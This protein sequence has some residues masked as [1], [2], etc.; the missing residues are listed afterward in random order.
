MK[1]ANYN[2]KIILLNILL[3][4]IIV[5]GKAN[6]PVFTSLV[7]AL[8]KPEAVY[9]LDLSNQKFPEF[10][11]SILKMTHLHELNL[12]NT[13]L[14]YLPEDI[15]Q[16]KHLRVLNVSH[17]PIRQLPPN[18]IKITHLRVLDLRHTELTQLPH[19][20]RLSHLHELDISHTL[21]RSVPRYFSKFPHLRH[22]EIAGL[23]L[24]SFNFLEYK[25][26]NYVDISENDFEEFP[27][28]LKHLR[29][30]HSLIMSDLKNLKKLPSWIFSFHYLYN[31]DISDNHAEL[32][33]D[34]H[35]DQISH[36][37]RLKTLN[38]S[39]LEL[40]RLPVD[41]EELKH[42]EALD[43]SG[44][45]LLDW[46]EIFKHLEKLPLQKLNLAKNGI[47]TIDGTHFVA[48]KELNL[49]GNQFKA[50]PT[51]SPSIK[52]LNLENNQLK[53][54]SSTIKELSSLE[55]LYL[56]KNQFTDI[57]LLF[58]LPLKKLSIHH[59][60]IPRVVIENLKQKHPTCHIE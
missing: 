9:K 52:T 20:S 49:S 5:W 10:P 19:I 33:T 47:D 57:N 23:H 22:L 41:W 8:E 40:T 38:L 35:W 54:V 30:M 29:N 7:K 60:P 15:A 32:F 37:K 53:Q 6:H 34:D 21:M 16:L 36:E 13:T 42:L 1:N 12:S 14:Q 4:G 39:N 25:H 27:T 56:A 46:N 3:L 18:I 59:N 11:M 43:L 31:L 45:P 48:L 28:G 2:K 50:M 51:F 55:E 44:N 17:N 24:T 58:D 26:L